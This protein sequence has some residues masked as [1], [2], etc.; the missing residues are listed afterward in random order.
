MR[1]GDVILQVS[2]GVTRGEEDCPWL[3]EL[4]RTRW[5]GDAEKF[6]RTVLARAHGEGN[7]DLSVLIPEIS[8]ARNDAEERDERHTA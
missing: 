7:D 6:A 3:S 4:L 5:D 8:F 1:A 2:D